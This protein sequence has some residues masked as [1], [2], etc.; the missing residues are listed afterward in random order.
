[1][2]KA[3]MHN[4]NNNNNNNSTSKSPVNQQQQGSS[5]MGAILILFILY[6]LQGTIFG[7]FTF[8]LPIIWAEKGVSLSDLAPLTFTYYP[9]TF[10]I[11]FAPFVDT[12]YWEW[13][14]KR[15]SYVVPIQYIISGMFFL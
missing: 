1:M 5:D 7:F 15:K 9:Y 6:W 4:K 13:L 3:K 11:L 12:Y 10:K 2:Q 8:T 14:G